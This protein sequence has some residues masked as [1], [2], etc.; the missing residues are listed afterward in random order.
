MKTAHDYLRPIIGPE[1]TNIISYADAVKAVQAVID[2]YEP[3]LP[4]IFPPACPRCLQRGAECLC[5]PLFPTVLAKP[6]PAAVPSKEALA[7][8]F[9][10]KYRGQMSRPN[11]PL[12]A[13]DIRDI[14]DFDGENEL[15]VQVHIR[16]FTDWYSIKRDA[17]GN[18]DP[19]TIE[20]LPF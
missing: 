14:M 17:S 9:Y 18:L 15:Q 20:Q 13:D 19:A 8:L 6:K 1:P 12:E 3:P 10:A 4:K 16:G 2:H 11:E 5:P 7:A